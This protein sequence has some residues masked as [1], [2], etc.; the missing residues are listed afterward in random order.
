MAIQNQRKE[1]VLRRLNR[2]EGQAKGLKRLV[3]E[4]TYCMDVINQVLSVHEALRGVAN[5]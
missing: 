4:D 1:H 5:S 2:I 3:K